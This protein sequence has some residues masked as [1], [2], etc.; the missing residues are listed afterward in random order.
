MDV[1]ERFLKKGERV[2]IEGEIEYRSYE[3]KDGVTKYITEIR[4]NRAR[5]TQG[6]TQALTALALA[7]GVDALAKAYLR[8]A[9]RNA[10]RWAD[11]TITRPL[12]G[13]QLNIR[14]LDPTVKLR[15][16]EELGRFVGNE[17]TTKCPSKFTAK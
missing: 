3:D 11:R 7:P 10:P 1:A 12:F 16:W 14:Q 13:K 2:Y 9:E 8:F 4:A 15:G 17:M 5:Y 6:M